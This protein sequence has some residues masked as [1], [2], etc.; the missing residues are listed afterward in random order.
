MVGRRKPPAKPVPNA[1]VASAARVTAARLRSRLMVEQKGWQQEAW[2]FYDTVGELRYAVDWIGRALSRATLVPARQA[3][4]GEEP[5]RLEDTDTPTAHEVLEAFA[6]GTSGQGQLLARLGVHL[7]V[8]GDSYLIGEDEIDGA[9]VPTGEQAW[10]VRSTDEV[11]VRAEQILVD[12]GGGAKAL[13]E[14]ALVIRIWQSHPRKYWEADSAV[15]AALPVLRQITGFGKHVDATVDSRLAG[16]GLL[17]LPNE[18]TFARGPGASEEEGDDS[19]VADL[20]ESMVTP[21]SD[22]DSAA[23]V[24]PVVVKIPG[25]HVDKVKHLSFGTAFDAQLESLLDKAIRRLALS[26]NLPPEVLLGMSAS[27]HWSAWQIDE[28]SLK[29]HVEPLLALICDAL[30]QGYYR[31]ALQAAGVA[32]AD[33]YIV[34]FD[35]SELRLRPNRA[36]EA[37]DLFDRFAIDYQALREASG[38]D[39]ADAPSGDELR[40]MILLSAAREGQVSPEL[41]AALLGGSNTALPGVQGQPADV[42]GGADNGLIRAVEAAVPEP[43]QRGVPGGGG[44]PA[45]APGLQASA[46]E[47]EPTED[48]TVLIPIQRGPSPGSLID[49]AEVLVLRALERAGNKRRSRA[50][51]AAM[52]AIPEYETHCHLTVTVG[53]VE[54]LLAGAW[55][56][57]GPVARRFAW[58]DDGLR[59]ALHTYARELL[60]AGAPYDRE[61]LEDFLASTAAP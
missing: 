47:P 48:A 18:V 33:S 30:T 26:L 9:G 55:S 27:N 40:A 36:P 38:F 1:L 7:S 12:D 19:F 11:I 37:K 24:V 35:T 25:E 45:R 58:S 22:R 61:A 32:D 8:P 4:R 41:L 31:P 49:A 5:E 50:D 59:G 14:D 15:R 13:G 6:G 53:D 46:G 10:R 43:A 16:A 29:L 60:L 42:P 51:A 34:W 28:A 57:A 2:A 52:A 3:S 20:I 39:D 44:A 23:A 17:V 56:L 54:R 21:I